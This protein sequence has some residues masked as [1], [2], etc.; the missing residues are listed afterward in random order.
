[1][2]RVHVIRAALTVALLTA[3]IYELLAWSTT[4]KSW[5]PVVLPQ[6]STLLAS[7]PDALPD[8][9]ES[10]SDRFPRASELVRSALNGNGTS[11]AELSS[12]ALRVVHRLPGYA[13]FNYTAFVDG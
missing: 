9:A 10:T 1:M 5:A 3:G 7:P 12:T 2:R 13:T 6:S 11:L 4:E 8:G